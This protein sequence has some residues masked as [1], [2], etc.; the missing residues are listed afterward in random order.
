MMLDTEPHFSSIAAESYRHDPPGN[1]AEAGTAANVTRA[2]CAG[3]DYWNGKSEGLM[4]PSDRNL[5]LESYFQ[6]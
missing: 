1:H 6:F 4:G 2:A 3:C 5:E